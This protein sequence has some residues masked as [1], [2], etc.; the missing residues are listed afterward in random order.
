VARS[1][2]DHGVGVVG[3]DAGYRVRPGRLPFDLGRQ[4][5]YGGDALA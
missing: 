4:A 3:D 1:Q 5:P 2:S